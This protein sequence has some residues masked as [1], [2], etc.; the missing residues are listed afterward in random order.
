MIK[1]NFKQPKYIFPLV[2]FVPL[3]ALIYFVMQT[4]GGGESGKQEVATDRINME[5]PEA[6]A[7]EA[8]DK[9]YEMSRRFGDEDAFTAVGSLGEE[10]TED[11]SL[12]HGYSEEELNRLDAAEA[13]RIRQQQEMEELER[14]LAE[15]RKHI[16]SYAYGDKTPG[17]DDTEDFARDLEEIQRRSYERQKAIESGLGIGQEEADEAARKQRADSIARVREEEK[18]RNRPNLV[19]KSE[20]T[21]AD[22]F[23]TVEAESSTADATL[24][25]AMIDQTTKA[26]EGT[27]LRFKLLD[28][29]TVSGTRLKKNTYLYGTVTGFG[30]QRVRA[31]ITSIL[32][33]GKFIKVNLSVFD[34]D[35]ME[36]FYVPES[37]FR[38]FVKDAGASTVQQ[39]ISFES[40]GYGSG[41]SG[42]A[43]ALQAL[44]NMYNSA[45]SA[46]SS[47]IRKNKAKIKY[48]T[49]VY[50]INSDEAR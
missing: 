50:L 24:I 21:N 3:C 13:E 15:S 32:V 35:G 31:A 39:N 49:I 9:M 46:L 19:I 42:E 36:G 8:G 12:E 30:Q 48:N 37:A 33:G 23:H 28:D 10:K 44:Q 1:V 45:T 6:R 25:R 18:E 17:N 27:R 2:I 38:D 5:L 14:S 20:E 7:E 34:N 40:D 16:N 11:E 47:N 22:K 26:K 41:I 43:V 4:F 29:V